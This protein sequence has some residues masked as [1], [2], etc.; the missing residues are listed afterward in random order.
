VILKDYQREMLR[1]SA[2]VEECVFQVEHAPLTEPG[3]C[4]GREFTVVKTPDI[5]LRVSRAFATAAEDGVRVCLRIGNVIAIDD[6]RE[7]GW[8]GFP[9]RHFDEFWQVLAD[10]PAFEI[11]PR[12]P[13]ELRVRYPDTFTPD[14]L[15]PGRRSTIVTFI[16]SPIS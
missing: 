1:R 9:L 5:R 16:G 3:G 4:R 11:G 12:A 13:V 7:P 15:V 2:K 14:G 6:N 10:R 8:P